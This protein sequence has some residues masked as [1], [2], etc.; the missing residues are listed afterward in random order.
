LDAIAF[1]EDEEMRSLFGE[2]EKCDRFLAR[3]RSAI[4]FWREGEVRSLFGERE[5]CDRFLA[6]GRSAIG[7]EEDEGMRSRLSIPRLDSF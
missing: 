6:R 4:A 3:G 5:K 1:E 2:R 7:F